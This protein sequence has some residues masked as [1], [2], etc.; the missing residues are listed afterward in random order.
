MAASGVVVRCPWGAIPVRE[1]DGSRIALA[2]AV[3]LARG[4]GDGCGQCEVEVEC[5]GGCRLVS[6]SLVSNARHVEV[7]DLGGR[8]VSTVRGVGKYTSLHVVDVDGAYTRYR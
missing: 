6:L 4:A 3:V 5:R 8:Y 1:C 2:E 7:Y